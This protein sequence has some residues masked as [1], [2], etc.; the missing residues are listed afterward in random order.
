[1]PLTWDSQTGRLASAQV[2]IAMKV[3]LV[4]RHGK[5]LY[6]NPGYDYHQQYE[7][8][9]AP[10]NFFQEDNPAMERLARDFAR[11]LVSNVLEGY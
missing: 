7:L 3:S 5:S 2:D 6:D 11:T 1:M 8:A 9:R 4:D 10:A